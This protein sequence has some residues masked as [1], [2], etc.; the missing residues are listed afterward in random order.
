MCVLF[1]LVRW[2]GPSRSGRPCPLG[3]EC[4]GSVEG[5]LLEVWFSQ[6]VADVLF[7]IQGLGLCV[8]LPARVIMY[9]HV[10]VKQR[11][12]PIKSP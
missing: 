2:V 11:A 6:G 1:A 10:V 8:F 12:G 7:L 9:L 4:S 5:S 3:V